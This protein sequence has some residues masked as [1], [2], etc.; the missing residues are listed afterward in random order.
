MAPG[1]AQWTLRCLRE[2]KSENA[3]A[4]LRIWTHYQCRNEATYEVIKKIT[5]MGDKLA[6][7]ALLELFLSLTTPMQ[8]IRSS[9][10]KEQTV[11]PTQLVVDS[12]RIVKA[13]AL[14]DSGCT[15]LCINAKFVQDNHIATRRTARP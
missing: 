6:C 13:L 1:T 7:Q 5:G 14:L 8:F 15:G 9:S 11:I 2:D 12:K 10:A 3:I 4:I